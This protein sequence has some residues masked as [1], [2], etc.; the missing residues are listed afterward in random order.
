MREKTITVEIDE[1]G[2]S[3]LDLT[4]FEG[5]GCSAVAKAFRARDQVR[6]E[7]RKREFYIQGQT[8]QTLQQ[9]DQRNE[10]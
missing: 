5:E 4:G 3:T 7:R 6:T 1:L 8:L 9:R 2:N 10:R